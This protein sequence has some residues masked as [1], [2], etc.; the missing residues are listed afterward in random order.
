MSTMQQ[1]VT[2]QPK[3]K[4]CHVPLDMQYRDCES[5]S[6]GWRCPI[7][8]EQRVMPSPAG[9]HFRWDD[10]C[11]YLVCMDCGQHGSFL[12]AHGNSRILLIQQPYCWHGM[13]M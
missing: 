13:E 4:T 2:F 8:K 1:E 7:C 3:C 12:A 11:G 6:C 9:H 5:G 10:M